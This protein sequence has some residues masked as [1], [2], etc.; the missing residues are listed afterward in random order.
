MK[1]NSS[2]SQ[3]KCHCEGSSSHPRRESRNH[4]LPRIHLTL[5]LC[6]FHR[7]HLT[8]FI[9]HHESQ[10][11]AASPQHPSSKKVDHLGKNE[12]PDNGPAK[13]PNPPSGPGAESEASASQVESSSPEPDFRWT[14]L[15]GS[16]RVY[17]EIDQENI[18]PSRNVGPKFR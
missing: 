15:S 8:S 16:T 18:P 11:H 9:H 10:S 14:S 12:T 17:T 13:N 2:I 6:N 1:P 3:V 5:C 4:D 7:A